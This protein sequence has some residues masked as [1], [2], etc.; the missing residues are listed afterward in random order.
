MMMQGLNVIQIM[1]F[2]SVASWE[3]VRR[4]AV[5]LHR[6]S[7]GHLGK[8]IRGETRFTGR[9][10]LKMLSSDAYSYRSAT[11]RSTKVWNTWS[12]S[13]FQCIVESQR[14]EETKCDTNMGARLTT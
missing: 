3:V 8:R 1:W 4:G 11:G 10:P 14:Y 5:P 6:M 2:R 9:L 12:Q 7:S 13:I